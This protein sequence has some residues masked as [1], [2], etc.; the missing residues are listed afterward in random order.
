MP[1]PMWKIVY[2]MGFYPYA[3]SQ[4]RD[5]P[6]MKTE[7]RKQGPLL[8]KI[9]Y[10]VGAEGPQELVSISP[11]LL[12]KNSVLK[13]KIFFWKNQENM[14]IIFERIPKLNIFLYFLLFSYFKPFFLNSIYFLFLLI[15][16]QTESEEFPIYIPA[17]FLHAGV[18]I[19]EL[20]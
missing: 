11:C 7:E 10:F 4:T 3:P 19:Q 12:Q 9:N 17:L 20:V 1:N 16:L 5:L 14:N 2:Q 6:P 8:N 13:D 18:L 15:F